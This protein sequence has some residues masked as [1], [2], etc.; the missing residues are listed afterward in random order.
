M[1]R[2]LAA[3]VILLAAARSFATQTET[4]VEKE[5]RRQAMDHY[6][7]GRDAM[8]TERFEEAVAEFKAAIDLDPL[9][10]IAYFRK[11]QA[12]M[13]LKEYAQAEQAFLGCRRAHENLAGLLLSNSEEVEREREEVNR[14]LENEVLHAPIVA[15]PDQR[16]PSRPSTL[17][18]DIFKL[19]RQRR[20]TEEAT[21]VPA[22]LN[23][24]LGSAYFRQGKMDL[25]EKEWKTA[26]IA[27][28]KLGEAHNN[29]AALYLMTQ[30][31]DDAE[32]ELEL[33]EKAGYH[34]H[35]RLKEDI[36]AH[37]ASPN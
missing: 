8:T 24:S 36:K 11:G 6:Q 9:H 3:A 37:K 21:A 29:L 23:V 31:F 17:E 2:P 16:V 1:R 25:A 10:S 18:Q 4:L 35:P 32:K 14:G 12:H 30:K 15:N 27:N 19:K 26:V 5:R 20:K 13:T 7:K 22:E 33:A 34:V 28:P